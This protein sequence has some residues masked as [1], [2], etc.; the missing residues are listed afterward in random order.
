MVKYCASCGKVNDDQANF[1]VGCGKSLASEV[2]STESLT[3]QK[4]DLQIVSTTLIA[5]RGDIRDLKHTLSD[6]FLKDESGNVLLVARKGFTVVNREG[7]PKG[8]II[9]LLRADGSMVF[10]G[11]RDSEGG[12]I[13]GKLIALATKHIALSVTDPSF[14]LMLLLACIVAIDSHR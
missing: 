9:T 1:C 13:Q 6:V 10:D 11:H 8:N 5:D 2:T 14:P 3:P 4:P 7:L 12:G